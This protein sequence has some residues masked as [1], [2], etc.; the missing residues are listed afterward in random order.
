M[1][2][3]LY[4]FPDIN[5]FDDDDGLN[6]LI[7]MSCRF[8]DLYSIIC[9]LEYLP[10]GKLLLHLLFGYL[11]VWEAWKNILPFLLSVFKI[12]SLF[13]INTPFLALL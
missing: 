11:A 8:W 9:Y 10:K 12:M 1:S 7:G 2:A 13:I 3:Y 5:S 6:P 4:F